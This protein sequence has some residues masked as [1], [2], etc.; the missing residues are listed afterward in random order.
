VIQECAS[1]GHQSADDRAKSAIVCIN[2]AAHTQALHL[3]TTS[4]QPILC[5]T[6]FGV[7]ALSH[8]V[9]HR[10]QVLEACIARNVHIIHFSACGQKQDTMHR[11]FCDRLSTHAPFG[12]G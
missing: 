4:M 2:G 7:V 10:D 11:L 5:W 8:S 6:C 9:S 3:T 12:D 1:L